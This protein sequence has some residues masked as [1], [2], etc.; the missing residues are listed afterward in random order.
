MNAEVA[1]SWAKVLPQLGIGVIALLLLGGYIYLVHTEN[2]Q[3]R[4]LALQL[5]QSTMES[6]AQDRKMSMDIMRTA[7]SKAETNRE[8]SIELANHISEVQKTILKLLEKI[9]IK[10]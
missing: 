5:N 6:A 2:A 8:K 7:L 4:D 9:E 1:S 10:P 3:E